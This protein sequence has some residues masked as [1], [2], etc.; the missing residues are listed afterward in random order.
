MPKKKK[1]TKAAKK[2]KAPAKRAA[3]KRAPAKARAAAKR[4]A[5]KAPSRKLAKKRKARPA[6]ARPAKAAKRSAARTAPKP[7]AARAKPIQRRDRPGHI[8]PKY[9]HDLLEKT[10]HEHDP[11]SFVERPRSR[12]DLVEQLGE[13]FVEETTSAEHKGEER[14]DQ[15]VPEELGGPFVET[16]AD[17]EFAHGT[18]PSNPKTSTREPFPRT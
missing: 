5:P 12:D 10:E 18:D 7:S 1:A 3:K 11:N 17:T 15:E 4:V 2:S 16:R 9:G 13:E 14:L 8:D 6:K